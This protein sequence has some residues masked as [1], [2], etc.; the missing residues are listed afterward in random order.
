M[1]NASRGA[2]IG[3]NTKRI[4]NLA[5]QL[6]DLGKLVKK[7]KKEGDENSDEILAVVDEVH[8]AHTE[9]LRLL[10]RPWWKRLFRMDLE[11]PAFII[12]GASTT[13][14]ISVPKEFA[15]FAI[16]QAEEVRNVEGRE[17]EEAGVAADAEPPAG[18]G[19]SQNT[20]AEEEEG[21]A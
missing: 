1:K 15:E 5:K 19:E 20:G 9:R 21:G 3:R 11:K 6:E 8:E 18:S 4:G 7:V 13:E 16:E 12:G 10:E 14:C 2:A 17:E